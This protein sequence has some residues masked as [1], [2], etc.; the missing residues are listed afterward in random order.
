M[1]IIIRNGTIVDGSG[2][3][4]YLGDVGI[5]AG[6]IEQIGHVEGEAATE[7]DATGKTVSPGFIDPH[8]HFDAQLL[9]DG[10]AKPAI[11]HGE[12]IQFMEDARNVNRTVGAMLSGEV[13]RHHPEGLP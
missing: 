2:R 6:R 3:P 10:A 7:I 1:D 9:W 11:E 4:A 5:S 8:T 13:T 12:R